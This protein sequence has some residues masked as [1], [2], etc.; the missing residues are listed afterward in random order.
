MADEKAPANACSCE[1]CRGACEHKPGWFKPEE[2]A[3]LA[4]ALGLTEQELF[5]QHLQ[6]D[7]WNGTEETDWEEVFILSPAII[8]GNPGDMFNSDPRGRCAWFTDGKCAIHKFGKPFECA[9]YHH[10]QPKDISSHKIVA[11]AWN[12]PKNQAKV[13]E[14]LGR[15]PEMTGSF[16]VFDMFT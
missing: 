5:N 7:W 12:T 1:I 6:V 9:A 10:D 11:L 2:I 14:L 15:E 3:P 13:R 4:A 16:S 8:G